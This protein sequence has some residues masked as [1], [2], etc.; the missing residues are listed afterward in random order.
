VNAQGPYSLSPGQ[1][2]VL[3]DPTSNSGSVGVQ[4]QNF[5]GFTLTVAPE[6]GLSTVAPNNAVTF[7]SF[8]GAPITVTVAGSSSG[9]AQMFAVWLLRGEQ[10]PQPDGPI[11]TSNVNT[12]ASSVASSSGVLTRAAD[13]TT[14]TLVAAPPAGW[15]NVFSQLSIA[16]GLTGPAAELILNTPTA[17]FVVCDVPPLSA[18]V[19]PWIFPIDFTVT[20]T[21][22]AFL[23]NSGATGDISLIAVYRQFPAAALL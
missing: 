7:P 12:E 19:Q 5:S 20:Q 14:Q 11:P 22:G 15:V 6:S 17:S 8:G 21:V 16:T 13:G 10:S 18:V 2:L 4:L 9:Q 1:V 3:M 23:S